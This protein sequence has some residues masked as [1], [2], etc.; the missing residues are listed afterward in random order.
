M[1]IR[2]VN[3]S[4]TGRSLDSRD[5]HRGDGSC[6]SAQ[7]VRS[8]SIS[9]LPSGRDVFAIAFKS[10]VHGG[11]DRVLGPSS[12]DAILQFAKMTD[13]LPHH[14]E[15]HESLVELFGEDGAESLERAIVKDLAE[16]MK[17]SLEPLNI[18]GT[19]DFEAT[20]R[21]AEKNISA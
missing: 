15:F 9:S 8:L 13:D 18:D 19:F 10:S 1:Q 7:G 2:K 20:M 14:R 16:R 17:W 6:Q 5:E 3:Y 4:L 12:T 21:A 11:L